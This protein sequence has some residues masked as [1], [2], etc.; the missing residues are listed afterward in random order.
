[1]K[2]VFIVLGVIVLLL[3]M[4]LLSSHGG[5]VEYFSLQTKLEA[6]QAENQQLMQSNASLKKEVLDLQSSTDSIEAIA[7]EKLGM[8]AKDEVFVKVIKLN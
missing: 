2:S 6:L 1:M 3:A 7:R 5:I 4:R 8:V